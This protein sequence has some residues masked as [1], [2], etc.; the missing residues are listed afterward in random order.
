MNFSF[1]FRSQRPLQMTR[2]W[3]ISLFFSATSKQYTRKPA[4]KNL[5]ITSQNLTFLFVKVIMIWRQLYL[6]I[7]LFSCQQKPCVNVEL[8][9]YVA[10]TWI[11]AWRN[12]VWKNYL[13]RMFF[14]Q[15]PRKRLFRKISSEGWEVKYDLWSKFI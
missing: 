8:T 1:Q 10:E 15:V 9:C 7:K 13:K 5:K 2:A 6:F 3:R 12:M 11:L 4:I 14:L